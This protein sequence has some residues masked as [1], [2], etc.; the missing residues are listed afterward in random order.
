[1][2]RGSASAGVVRLLAMVPWIASQPGG[3]SIAEVCDRFAIS[4]KQL[5]SDLGALGMVG[6]APHSP[7]MFVEVSLTDGWVSIR[8]QWFDRPP[9]L[10]AAQGLALV[11]AAESLQAVQGSDPDGPLARALAKVEA[12]IGVEIGRDVDVDLG[13]ADETVIE[14]VSQAA[15]EQTSIDVTYYSHGSDRFTDRTIE[16]WRV[17]SAGGYWYTDAWCHVAG[18][19]RMF[20]LDRFGSVEPSGAKATVERLDMPD[21]GPDLYKPG[22]DD[23]GVTLVIDAD[24]HWVIERWNTESV[25][26]LPDGRVQVELS[27][28]SKA[29]LERILMQLGHRAQVAASTDPAAVDRPAV[30]RRLLVRYR[31]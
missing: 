5:E 6:I 10:T 22:S 11:A 14:R 30:A 8:P 24:M 17:F 3:V 9:A 31:S 1:M 19:V 2:S 4:A 29:W 26:T 20:R 25:V 12:S 23:V 13:Y 16:P 27:V 21:H 15:R 7:D 18:D 28:G